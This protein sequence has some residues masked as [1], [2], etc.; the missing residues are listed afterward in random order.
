MKLN[1]K[2]TF[3][4]QYVVVK[5][6]LKSIQIITYWPDDFYFQEDHQHIYHKADLN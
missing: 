4:Q 5:Q 3:M 6:Y 2:S 1:Q